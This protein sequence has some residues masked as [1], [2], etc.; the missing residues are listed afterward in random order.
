MSI[1]YAVA[2][3][4]AAMVFRLVTLAVSIRNERALRKAGAVEHGSRNSSAL[5]VAHLAYYV[6]AAIEGI[7]RAAAFDAT[8]AV[9]LAVYLFGAFMLVVVIRTLGSLWTVKLIIARNHILVTNRLFRI[10]RHP[11]YYLNILPE[12]VGFALTLHAFGTLIVGLPIYLIP[13]ILRVRQEERVMHNT[14]PGY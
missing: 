14:F 1:S 9:G 10:V 3:V 6:A 13:L 8:S 11:N 5:A 7:R 2:F 4:A 12:L